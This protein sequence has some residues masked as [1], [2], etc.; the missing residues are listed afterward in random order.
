[1]SRK[2]KFETGSD[3]V[4]TVGFGPALVALKVQKIMVYIGAL[5]A[6]LLFFVVFFDIHIPSKLFQLQDVHGLT[7]TCLLLMS[8]AMMGRRGFCKITYAR[9]GVFALVSILCAL[10]LAETLWPDLQLSNRLENGLG[11]T[12][13]QHIVMGGNTAIS[14]FLINFGALMRHRVPTLSIVMI[15]AG[16]V[17]PSISA[18]GYSYVHHGYYGQ[19]SLATTL[20]IMTLGGA[21]LLLF[22]RSAL[23]RPFLTTSSWGRMARLQ[24][25]FVVGGT[26]L[27]GIV[28]DR[29]GYEGGVEAVVGGVIWLF[30]VTM[31]VTGPL[32]E[33]VDRD[34][35]A[36]EREL[37]RKANFDPLT[38]LWNRRAVHDMQMFNVADDS[39]HRVSVSDHI[40]VIMADVD[41]FKRINDMAGHD[42]G[43]RVLCDISRVLRERVR[44]LDVVAR[45]GGEEFLVLLPDVSIEKTMEIAQILR[46]AVATSVSWPNV[47]QNEPVTLSIGVTAMNEQ[48]GKTL[49]MALQD[50]DHALYAAKSLG[51]NR[52]VLYGNIPSLASKE[53]VTEFV[54][55]RSIH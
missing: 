25:L 46:V 26:W 54:S 47:G 37:R 24:L 23:L 18:L 55:N 44:G 27:I 22:V 15:L 14:L 12:S 4:G 53:T 43:D 11:L 6:A 5:G 29:S 16:L 34:R 13:E 7:A 3:H 35:R 51:R 21:E 40:G 52:V 31:L 2:S 33:R 50:A 10:R 42:E 38:G 49:E 19:M 30:L 20:I 36:L 48:A 28:I 1:M 32:F 39:D 45:W 9:D 8:I 41:M 17:L